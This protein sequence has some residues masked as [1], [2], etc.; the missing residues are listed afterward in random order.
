MPGIGRPQEAGKNPFGGIKMSPQQQ[1][2]PSMREGES[3]GDYL[4]RI[5]GNKSTI[6]YADRKAHNQLGKDGF[7][8]LLAH[9]MQNQDPSNPMD[10]KQFAADLAQFAQLEQLTNMNSTMKK[11]DANK[12]AELKSMGASFLG[13]K[14]VTRGTSLNFD[15]KKEVNIPFGLRQNASKVIV[16]IMDEKNQL[17]QQLNYEQMLKGNQTVSW[18]GMS[19]NGQPAAKGDY[20]IQVFAWDE[21]MTPF[22]GVTK[23]EGLVTGVSFENG[24][25]ILKV[26][27]K[28][29][30]FLRDVESFQMVGDNNLNQTKPAKH[31]VKSYDQVS[32]MQ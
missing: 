17:V 14:V 30:I 11:Q 32:Q 9:Q 12:N 1:S 8:K 10:Q 15:G 21:N 18:D 7:M 29:S 20:S 23:S 31:A 22:A 26:D 6:E 24:E 3:K 19:T 2:A 28:K 13:K 5:S 4:N 25:T 27:G 16:R